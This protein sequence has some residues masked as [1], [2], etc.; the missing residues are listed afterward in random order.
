MSSEFTDV[1]QQA[2]GQFPAPELP[3]ERVLRRRDVRR[4]NRRIASAAL[5]LILAAAAIGGA[6]RVLERGLRQLP[7]NRP[8]T[9]ITPQNVQSLHVVGTGTVGG[10]PFDVQVSD[11]LAYV[12]TSGTPSKLEAFSAECTSACKPVWVAETGQADPR[13]RAAVADGMVYV[14]TDDLYAFS[15]SCGIAGATCEPT[16]VGH[17]DGRPFE[18]IVGADAV[19]VVSKRKLYSFPTSCSSQSAECAPSWVSVELPGATGFHHPVVTGAAVYVPACC[20]GPYTRSYVAFPTDCGTGGATCVPL[21]GAPP[22][23]PGRLI[24]DGKSFIANEYARELFAYPADCTATNVRPSGDLRVEPPSCR[25]LWTA[26]GISSIRFRATA[27]NGLLYVNQYFGGAGAGPNEGGILAYPTD[28]GTGN[29]TCKPVWTWGSGEDGG[30]RLA[31]TSVAITGDRL[32]ATSANGNLYVFGAGSRRVPV[33]ASPSSKTPEI[34]FYAG[35]AVA[36]GILL[37]VR[38]RRAI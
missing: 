13:G 27:G 5:A 23:P 21:Q 1:L 6:I 28:C 37:L 35:V 11:A 34:V 30:S 26:S 8:S 3:L 17:V 29:A 38:R 7:A 22:P 36:A 14:A 15:A 32:Y 2:R 25:L 16:W 12:V 4:R 9:P 24:A 10:H 20:A 33:A 31:L 18:P 19:Y